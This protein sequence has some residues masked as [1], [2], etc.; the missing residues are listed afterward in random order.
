MRRRRSFSLTVYLAVAEDRVFLLLY[1]IIVLFV[2]YFS[3]KSYQIGTY[4]ESEADVY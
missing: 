3:A 2:Y 1:T 4:L